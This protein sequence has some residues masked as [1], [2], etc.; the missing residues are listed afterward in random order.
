MFWLYV[1]WDCALIKLNRSAIILYWI[2]FHYILD[3]LY[4]TVTKVSSWILFFSVQF[5]TTCDFEVDMCSLVVDE[6]MNLQWQRVQ[7]NVEEED[8]RP[9]YDHTTRL[10]Q[11]KL[12]AYSNFITG[13]FKLHYG[14][15]QIILWAYSN[16]I[17]GFFK[18]TLFY[19]DFYDYM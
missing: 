6:V 10:G 13:L 8:G 19:M 1:T 12:R 5:N 9:Y 17:M 2:I 11:I 18:F 3:I 7:S 16:Y 14:L 4:N 15:I